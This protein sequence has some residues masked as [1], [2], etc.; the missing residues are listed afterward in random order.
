MRQEVG[1]P[2]AVGTI[3]RVEWLTPF[4]PS[5]FHEVWGIVDGAADITELTEQDANSLGAGLS[6]VLAAYHRWNLTS[7]NFALIGGGP[8]PHEQRYQVVLKV[9]SRSNAEPMYRSDATY[10]ERLYGEALIDLSPEEI[11]DG[12]R[13]LF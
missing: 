10:F 8:R 7:F 13:P 2:R 4:A 11:A 3:G 6:R 12:L 5:G 1:G 9:L